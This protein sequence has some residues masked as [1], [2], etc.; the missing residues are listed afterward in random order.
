MIGQLNGYG[1]C[2]ATNSNRKVNA[3]SEKNGGKTEM[4][5]IYLYV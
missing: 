2:I 4:V 1:C 3:V 5:G